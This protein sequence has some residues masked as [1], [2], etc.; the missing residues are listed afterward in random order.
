VEYPAPNPHE[1][2]HV[3]APGPD[4]FDR[5]RRYFSRV[6]TVDSASLPDEY[7]PFIYESRSQWPTPECPWRPPMPGDKHVDIVPICYV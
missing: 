4:Y 2:D 7:Q 6:D 3:R 5:Y 1:A